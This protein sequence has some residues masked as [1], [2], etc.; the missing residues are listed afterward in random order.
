[1]VAA[2][3]AADG[4]RRADMAIQF[5]CEA[6]GRLI[7]VGDHFAGQHGHCKHCGRPIVIPQPA[8]HAAGAD[9]GFRLKPA[10][11]AEPAGVHDHLLNDH[12]PLGVR[13]AEAEPKVEP[14]SIT[15]PD[16]EP[17][18]PGDD[19]T[20]RPP[21]VK[22]QHSSAGPP[23]FWVNIPTLTARSLARLFRT[24][25][26]WGYMISLAFLVLALIGFVFG[27][28][29]ALHVGVVVAIA[30]NIEMLVVGVAYLVTLPFKE[31]LHHG[32]MNFFPPYALY[33]WYTR[34]PQMKVPVK[35]TI[36]A[37]LP[38]A[39]AATF[40]FAYED[41]AE[42]EKK[43]VQKLEAIEGKVERGVHQVEDKVAPGVEKKIDKVLDG[44]EG[45]QSR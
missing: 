1:M 45:S 28:K 37:F 33:Y 23:P 6:C 34:W 26:D 11:G 25:R 38:M 14:R 21:S 40:Y 16:T 41:G 30:A 39:L 19:Y 7:E 32:L 13:H 4:R 15:N 29:G 35:K 43:A 31:S 10:E 27:L 8:H 17:L 3:P 22:V 36:G 24:L 44:T 20:I 2:G 12:T 18:R 5:H 9:D 42:F